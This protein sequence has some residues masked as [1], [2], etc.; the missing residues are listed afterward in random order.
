MVYNLIWSQVDVSFIAGQGK[1]EQSIGINNFRIE[2]RKILDL[3]RRNLIVPDPPQQQPVVHF[4]FDEGAGDVLHHRSRNFAPAEIHGA[5]WVRNGERWALE[6]DGKNGFVDCGK[7][8]VIGSKTL[9]AWIYAEPIY[10]VF[11]W[12]PILGDG[13][14]QLY[15]HVHNICAGDATGLLPFQKWVHVA[16]TWNGKSTR[17]YIDGTLVSVSISQE[18]ASRAKFLLAGSRNHR[19]GS[20]RLQ[21]AIQA[22]NRIRNAL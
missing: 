18:P 10:S 15:Q 11:L 4:A 17:L 20:S 16:Q 2:A 19:K 6:F 9:V 12:V 13:S 5:T 1:G 8:R 7:V 3:K 22:Q 14:C 21:P